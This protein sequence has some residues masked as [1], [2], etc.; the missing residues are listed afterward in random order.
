MTG[1]R[2]IVAAAVLTVLGALQGLDWAQL[3]PNNPEVVGWVLT[4]I[5]A[6]MAVLRV[7][8]K[9]PVGGQK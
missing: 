3:I 4:G 9:T 1:Y 8:T 6:V 5:G 7:V 2:T